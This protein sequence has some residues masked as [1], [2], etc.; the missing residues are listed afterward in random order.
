[1]TEDI[2]QFIA[3]IRASLEQ[4]SATLDEAAAAHFGKAVDE[5]TDKDF[6]ALRGVPHLADLVARYERDEAHLQQLEAE[7]GRA[8]RD[9]Q[10]LIDQEF[11]DED[12]QGGE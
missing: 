8:E 1:M 5:F 7:A 4:T 3:R 10:A 11:W 9:T 6:E 2:A 12:L